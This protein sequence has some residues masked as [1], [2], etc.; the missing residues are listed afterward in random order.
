MARSKKNAEMSADDILDDILEAEPEDL[1]P[2]SIEGEE[3]F[4]TGDEEEP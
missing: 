2:E 1:E 4:S 3:T